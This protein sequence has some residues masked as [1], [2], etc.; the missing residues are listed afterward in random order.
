[1]NK[2]EQCVSQQTEQ[3]NSITLT[4]KQPGQQIPTTTFP[5][6]TC[7]HTVVLC[8]KK[9]SQDVTALIIS[10]FPLSDHHFTAFLW[11]CNN[12]RW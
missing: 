11:V 2:G 3:C 1:M 10:F 4:V 8:R 5:I 9:K 7:C 12:S 6:S